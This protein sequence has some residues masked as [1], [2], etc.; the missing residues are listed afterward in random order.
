[1][2]Q[3]KKTF[4]A[5]L[6]VY[7]SGLFYVLL[8]TWLALHHSRHPVL[9]GRYSIRFALLLF[10]YA[11]FFIPYLK[12]IRFLFKKEMAG[13]NKD[14]KKLGFWFDKILAC[15]VSVLLCLTPL[16][17]Y[18]RANVTD[19]FQEKDIRRFHPFLQAVPLKNDDEFHI[20]S[21]GFR[22]REITKE[23]PKNTYRIF[24]LGG[25]SVF[26]AEVPYQMS[27]CAIL[28]ERLRAHYPGEN[29]E[30]LNAGFGW[31][32]TEHSLIQY[33]F[34]IKD[35]HPDLIIIS[36][37]I[38]DLYRSFRPSQFAFGVFESDYSHFYGAVSRMAKQY[39]KSEPIFRLHLVSLVYLLRSFYSKISADRLVMKTMRPVDISEFP[40][41][42]SFSRNIVSTIQNLKADKVKLILATQPV[43]YREGLTKIE[44]ESLW[45]LQTMGHQNGKIPSLRSMIL[46]MDMFNQKMRSLAQTHEVFLIDLESRVSKTGT[47]FLDDCHYTKEGN[48]LVGEELFEF[49]VQNKF[50]EAR[51]ST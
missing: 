26:A 48:A 2:L 33:L 30:V 13:R 3:N 25:S 43:L 5:R 47:Y 9:L 39:F 23:K 38:N 45:V 28:E 22:G 4:S 20:N 50:L 31:Y 8:T 49:V 14:L 6:P 37:G 36:H 7:V 10:S 34:K 16:E 27:S 32:T 24:V 19:F 35:Y 46:G 12:M 29:I 17:I 15:F 1:M 51:V 21:H 41:L 40:S 44:S 42:E 11:I 18:L